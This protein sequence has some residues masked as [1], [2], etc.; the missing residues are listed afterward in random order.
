MGWM[1][2]RVIG[3]MDPA[4]ASPGPWR[5]S[6]GLLCLQWISD[7]SNVAV[8][9]RPLDKQ[10][11]LAQPVNVG[12]THRSQSGAWGTSGARKRPPGDQCVK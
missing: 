6:D 3:V 4:A 12:P 7:S 9:Y 10:A 2:R 5:I 11:S 8:I 1:G